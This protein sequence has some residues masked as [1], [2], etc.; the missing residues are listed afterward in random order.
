[1]KEQEEKLR[2]FGIWLHETVFATYQ[3]GGVY[4]GMWHVHFPKSGYITSEELI[5]NWNDYG[6]I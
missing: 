5:K 4:E 1:M 2:E 3:L 6:R